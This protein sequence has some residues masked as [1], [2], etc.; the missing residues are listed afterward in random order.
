[1]KRSASTSCSNKG[2]T[3]AL[4]PPYKT[5]ARLGREGKKMRFTNWT[6]AEIERWL[7]LRAVEWS[8]FPAFVSQPLVPFM[9]LLFS[10][11]WVIAIVIVLN[12]LWGTIR[13]SYVN[14]AVAKVACHFVVLAKWPFAIGSAIYLFIH[15]Q[16]VPALIALVWPLLVG[17]ITIPGK[18]GVIELAFAKKI[19]YVR[20]DAEL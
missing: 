8:A 10:W 1:M 16:F 20:D 11:Y 13:Y 12:I 18:I 3:A 9:F 4:V 17:H 15:R 14:I 5:E 6:N 19:G 2:G 7:L